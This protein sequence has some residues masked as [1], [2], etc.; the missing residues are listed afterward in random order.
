[1][2]QEKSTDLQPLFLHISTTFR[3]III[4]GWMFQ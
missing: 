2:E 3:F 1:M 4:Q